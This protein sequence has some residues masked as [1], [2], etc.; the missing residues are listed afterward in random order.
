MKNIFEKHALKIII[1]TNLLY[2]IPFIFMHPGFMLD[3]FYI[4]HLIKTF[5]KDLFVKSPDE[6]FFLFFRPLSFITFRLDYFLW[7]T[8]F[9]PMKIMSL[10]IHLLL[11]VSLYFF[12]T[13]ISKLIELK[14]NCIIITLLLIIF[15]IHSDAILWIIWISN[16][17]ELL[18]LLFYLLSIFAFLQYMI[19]SKKR[20]Y[21]ILSTISF[22]L[23]LLSKQSG[24]HI[25]IL[26]FFLSFYI[27]KETNIKIKFNKDLFVFFTILIIIMSAFLLVNI[28]FA[29]TN[30]NMELFINNLWK[31]PFSL[32]G[33][34][35]N[36]ILPD[37][38]NVIYYF[39]LLNKLLAISLFIGLILGMYLL[40][41]KIQLTN[42]LYI[43]IL[44]IIISFPR[45][46][47]AG[48]TRINSV[49]LLWIIIILY[50]FFTRINNN[51]S[52]VLIV[53]FSIWFI[54]TGI[55]KANEHIL[56]AKQNILMLKSL[57]TIEEK[58][59]SKKI[60]DLSAS[61]M[62]KYEYYYFKNNDFGEYNNIL[63]SH[64]IIYGLNDEL[65]SYI[66]KN[67]G[68]EI[69]LFNKRVVVK[70][71]NKNTF[72]DFDYKVIKSITIEK[73]IVSENSRGFSEIIYE[74][75][76][77]YDVSLIKV[78]YYN[79]KKWIELN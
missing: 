29:T 58:N 9:I 19:L 51:Y 3:D 47:T 53:F 27:S 44:L 30:D 74:L 15:S 79:G 42:V 69:R 46:F 50:M 23:S 57:Q 65:T 24:L 12:I 52:K 48:G 26:F 63:S 35:L 5:P 60:L 16:R 61:I 33:I 7:A 8:N 66:K 21:L 70:S 11:I 13:K 78:V 64:F 36:V 75:P 55:Y 2:Y 41:G 71:K 43:V 76:K 59:K 62:R 72:F 18:M 32:I 49:F 34:V 45:I 6:M 14:I 67:V 37:F 38:G 68:V 28:K 31:K 54:I 22:I 25:P 56:N 20:I 4:F 17:T 77:D 1:I 10:V 73:T 40:R 39:F